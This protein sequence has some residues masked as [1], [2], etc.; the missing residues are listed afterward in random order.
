MPPKRDT[1]QRDRSESSADSVSAIS[2][3]KPDHDEHCVDLI[4]DDG[5]APPNTVRR[6]PGANEVKEYAGSGYILIYFNSPSNKTHQVVPRSMVVVGNL[7][8]THRQA[9]HGTKLK[10]N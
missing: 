3:A 2:S 6:P 5:S 10:T 1:C 8:A 7:S 4:Q 9:I